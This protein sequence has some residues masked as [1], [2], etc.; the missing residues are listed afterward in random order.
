MKEF[1]IPTPT[2]AEL[3]PVLQL[4]YRCPATAQITSVQELVTRIGLC[5]AVTVKGHPYPYLVAFYDLLTIFHHGE[6][7]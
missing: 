6:P 1:S 2:A 4:C 5:W 7:L 3:I